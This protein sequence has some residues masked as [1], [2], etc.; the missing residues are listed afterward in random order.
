M[1]NCPSCSQPISLTSS[2]IKLLRCSHCGKLLAIT[3]MG[4][5]TITTRHQGD[6]P[7][8]GFL[9][10]GAT[11][12]HEKKRFTITGRAFASNEDSVYNYWQI[13]FEKGDTAIL[14]EGY[15]HYAIL[16][17]AV[18]VPNIHL[19]ILRG[20]TTGLKTISPNEKKY[21]L[22]RKKK[23][24]KFLVEGEV[25]WPD[26]DEDIESFELFNEKGASLE[27]IDFGKGNFIVYNSVFY[28][29]QQLGLPVGN[30]TVT[31]TK[32]RCEK[33]KA[34]HTVVAFPYTYSFNCIQCGAAHTYNHTSKRFE[35]HGPDK[36]IPNPYI[37]IGS[38]GKLDNIE[39]KVI[40]MASKQERNADAAV[41]HEYTL[42]NP[43]QGFAY[44]SEFQGNWVYVKEWPRPP[45]ITEKGNDYFV[46]NGNEFELF[47][48][49][50]YKVLAAAGEHIYDLE[51]TNNI[52]VTEFIAPPQTLIQEMNNTEEIW[53]FGDH[54]DSNVL[55]NNFVMPRGKPEKY[56][57]GSVEP[58][59]IMNKT[60]FMLTLFSG[61]ALIFVLHFI[62]ATGKQEKQL[63]SEQIVF[64]AGQFTTSGTTP[65]FTLTKSESNLQVNLNTSV[66]NSWLEAEGSFVNTKTGK[67]YPFNKVVEF[68]QG[69]EEGEH[70]TEGNTS[71]DKVIT[72]IPAGNYYLEYKVVQDSSV[73]SIPVFNTVGA[74]EYKPVSGASPFQLEVLYDVPLHSNM[75]I[76]AGLVVLIGIIIYLRFYFIDKKRWYNS[77]YSKYSYNE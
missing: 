47:N 6:A 68:Y 41:W 74:S 63:F 4:N 7:A 12:T 55:A 17:I 28:L 3:E 42:Y 39:F 38:I 60:D 34:S 56:G 54:L 21:R 19:D 25:S 57:V 44:L 14:S 65:H 66:N 73:G 5:L 48:D 75:F 51:K 24:D 45:L 62:F 36:Q 16:T 77:K 64:P 11:G 76:S 67:E 29:P 53:F 20:L 27:V 46:E 30:S 71:E 13:T 32:V 49:Y 9:K 31:E 43:V 52:K 22:V 23:Y 10:L 58:V 72:G 2:S 15:G 40:G 33:C 18:P 1:L 70:W 69:Y 35:K 26:I 50:S 37:E 59:G 8:T 61:L